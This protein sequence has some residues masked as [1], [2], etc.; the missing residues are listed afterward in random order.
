MSLLVVFIHDLLAFDEVESKIYNTVIEE[1]Q[2]EDFLKKS[3]L[4]IMFNLFVIN[5]LEEKRRSKTKLMRLHIYLEMKYLMKDFKLHKLN[6]KKTEADK[7]ELLGKIKGGLDNGLVQYLDQ[8]D[9]FNKDRVSGDH[10]ANFLRDSNNMCKE[11]NAKLIKLYNLQLVLRENKSLDNLRET[12]EIYC[13]KANFYEEVIE[14]HRNQ[15]IY[16]SEG[17]YDL[18]MESEMNDEESESIYNTE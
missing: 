17:E 16:S 5:Y 9:K 2:S 18:G 13:C 8:L 6:F 12:D 15:N 4:K 1:K 10:V 11:L 7:N 3:A 14:Y